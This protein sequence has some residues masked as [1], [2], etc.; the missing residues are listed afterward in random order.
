MDDVLEVLSLPLDVYPEY[1]AGLRAL[2]RESPLVITGYFIV[3]LPLAAAAIYRLSRSRASFRRSYLQCAVAAFVLLPGAVGEGGITIA[4]L[5]LLVVGALLSLSAKW[6][7]LT[8]FY[9]VWLA[10][11]AAAIAWLVA[12]CVH[13]WYVKRIA[14]EPQKA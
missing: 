3:A 14:A 6:I 12:L 4:P 7:L 1:W 11:I 5:A 9:N 8:L 13:R 10:L 2:F